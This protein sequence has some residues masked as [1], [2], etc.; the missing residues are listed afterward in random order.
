MKTKED[1]KFEI[2]QLRKDK[3]IYALES[4]ASSVALLMVAIFV[5]TMFPTTA[6]AFMVGAA[7]ILNIIYWLFTVYGNIKRLS[8]IK[9]LERIL[10]G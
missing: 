2:D 3:M 9:K 7:F 10:K 8:R 1:I 6:T 5:G 4:I